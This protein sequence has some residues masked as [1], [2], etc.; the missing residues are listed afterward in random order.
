[1]GPFAAEV[2]DSV[3]RAP[4]KRNASGGRATPMP[5]LTV[6]CIVRSLLPRHNMSRPL[7]SMPANLAGFNLCGN[8]ILK[9]AR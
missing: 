3:V 4:R 6:H 7:H 1:M 8:S 5:R 2:G 9:I